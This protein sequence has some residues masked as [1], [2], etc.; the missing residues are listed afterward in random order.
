MTPEKPFSFRVTPLSSRWIR[1]SAINE[2]D[3]CTSSTDNETFF[4]VKKRCA[5]SKQLHL[6]LRWLWL[7]KSSGSV[8]FCVA[9]SMT[10]AV[11]IFYGQSVISR[12][13]TLRFGNL[14][15]GGTEKSTR[16]QVLYPVENPPK[17]NR[18]E[19]YRAVP[20]RTLQWKSAIR[21][22]SNNHRLHTSR[23]TSLN[24]HIWLFIQK[25]QAYNC[26]RLNNSPKNTYKLV[27]LSFHLKVEGF[28]WRLS[29]HSQLKPALWHT[30]VRKCRDCEG[31]LIPAQPK[32][33]LRFVDSAW[34]AGIG[35]AGKTWLGELCCCLGSVRN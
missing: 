5:H 14:N 12:V 29:F 19:P 22:Y 3:V 25:S 27:W 6:I 13:Y 17:V 7:F 26:M 32:W 11:M 8:V 18:T 35:C 31:K 21:H 20:C 23:L 30:Y 2:R 28:C 33:Q 1:S 24:L 34:A 15:R 10:Q 16:Y 9:S 4:V